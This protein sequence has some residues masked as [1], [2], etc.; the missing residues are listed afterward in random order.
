MREI[1]RHMRKSKIIFKR[2]FPVK[3]TLI[4]RGDRREERERERDRKWEED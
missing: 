1:R 2:T 3:L 4:K